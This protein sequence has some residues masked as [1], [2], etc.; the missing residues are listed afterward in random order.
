MILGLGTDI[1]QISRIAGLME[2]FADKFVQRCFTD[3]ECTRADSKPNPAAAYARLYAAKEAV[4]K[5]LGTGMR[6]GLAW[7]DIEVGHTDLGAPVITI[8]HGCLAV[9]REKT[10]REFT[11]HLSLSDDGDYAVATVIIETHP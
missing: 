11:C 6:E 4:L 2:K 8:K 9:I 5:A 1:V 10:S 7:H 3:S